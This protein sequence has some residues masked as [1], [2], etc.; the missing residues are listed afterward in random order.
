MHFVR[1]DTAKI[2]H[3]S[4][5]RGIVRT[6]PVDIEDVRPV[7]EFVS[8]FLHGPVNVVQRKTV[9]Q[10][11]VFRDKYDIAPFYSI[12]FSRHFQLF[13]ISLFK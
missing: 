2:V 12:N 4:A 11:I 3:Q 9:Q 10:H 7:S 1:L 6:F 13:C 8:R 5:Q